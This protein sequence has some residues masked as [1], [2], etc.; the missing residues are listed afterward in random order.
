LSTITRIYQ[1]QPLA[2]DQTI[3]LDKKASH[4]L[5][6]VLRVRLN[7]EIILFNGD[8]YEYFGKIVKIVKKSSSVVLE[9]K[10]S[11]NRESVFNIHLIQGVAK[12]DKMD[13]IIQKATELGVVSI[14]PILTKRSDVKLSHEGFEKKKARWQK[15]I[16]SAC[17]QSGRNILPVLHDVQYFSHWIKNNNTT[18]F[19]I[20]DPKAIQTLKNLDLKKEVG[21]IIGSE[22]GFSD[23]EIEQAK[24]RGAYAVCLGPR[25][26]RTETAGLAAIS[27]LQTL[28][29][30][31]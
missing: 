7:Q 1:N 12:G 5:L 22:G 27:A 23:Q 29:G 13:F 18:Q 8:G 4:Y 25:I 31:F 26:L 30:D 15:V 19:V 6:N 9:K 21:L 16:I 3:N 14:Q 2:V 17:E 11:K 10:E 24:A 20:L 28:F